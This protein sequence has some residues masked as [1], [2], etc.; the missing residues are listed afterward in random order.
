MFHFL[1]G[2]DQSGIA[3]HGSFISIF[4]DTVCFLQQSCFQTDARNERSRAAIQRIG[5]KFEGIVRAERMASD[6]TV[7]DT[8]R[9]SIVLSEWLE[10]KANLQLRLDV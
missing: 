5:G 4:Y 7:R 2:E 1:G 6:F 9:F 3:D 8:A 10:V